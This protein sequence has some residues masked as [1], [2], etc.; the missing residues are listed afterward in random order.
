MGYHSWGCK[1]S[2]TT[3]A[4]NTFIG[5]DVLTEL[6]MDLERKPFWA[7][8]HFHIKQDSFSYRL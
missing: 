1:E 7:M 5:Q 4:T 2:D 8:F 3:E 6:K